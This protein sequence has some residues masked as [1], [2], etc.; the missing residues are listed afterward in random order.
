MGQ[1]FS[2]FPQ[3]LYHLRRSQ[4]LRVFNS[5]PDETAFYRVILNR[6]TVT[7]SIIMIQPSLTCYS[8]SEAPHPVLLDAMSVKPD[9]ILLLD[10]YFQVLIHYGE[11]IAQWRD[12]NYQDQ[13]QYANFK[14]L[15]ELP[16]QD[17]QA[18]LADRFPCPR[19]VEA[20]E[21][22]S[23]ARILAAKVNPST[24]FE[25]AAY[26]N[27]QQFAVLTH[28]ASLQVFMDHLKKLAVSQQ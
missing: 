9:N 27:Q 1:N 7:N 4:F 13:P 8:F 14:K 19:F 17:A 15:L 18:L 28:D 10:T 6:E 12:A 16:K 24:S 25:Q 11:T 20:D 23:Q 5:S 26:G 3:F 22:S 21:Y 2:L